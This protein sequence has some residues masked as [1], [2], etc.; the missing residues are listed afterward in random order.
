VGRFISHANG[1][2]GEVIILNDRQFRIRG[3]QYSGARGSST[4]FMV[5][6]RGTA[7][8]YSVKGVALPDERGKCNGLRTY[9]GEDIIITMPQDFSISRDLAAIAVYDYENCVNFGHIALPGGSVAV[10]AVP[11]SG[12]PGRSEC[13]PYFRP[14]SRRDTTNP[15]VCKSRTGK[16]RTC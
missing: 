7:G 1:V 13:L 11:R 12:V 4:H 3:F 10:P 16:E 2:T 8:L 15:G 9:K 5:M 6:E 14:C